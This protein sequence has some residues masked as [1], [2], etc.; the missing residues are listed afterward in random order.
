MFFR[1]TNIRVLSVSIVFFK[2]DPQHYLEEIEQKD[3]NN[4]DTDNILSMHVVM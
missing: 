2:I 3:A 4:A 1:K